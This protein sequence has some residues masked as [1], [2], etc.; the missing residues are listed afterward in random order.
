VRIEVRTTS[1]GV[2]LT[3]EG[4]GAANSVHDFP[5][6]TLVERFRGEYEQKLIADGFKLQAVAERRI[7]LPGSGPDREERRRPQ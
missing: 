3:I 4:P 1:A 6:G 5:P 7:D 2:Q